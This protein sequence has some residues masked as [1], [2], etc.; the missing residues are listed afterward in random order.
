M[1]HHAWPGCVHTKGS[2]T[3]SVH[4]LFAKHYS[5]HSER[6][7]PKCV[8]SAHQAR[9]S[10]KIPSTK[11]QLSYCGNKAKW[12]EWGSTVL[13]HCQP[14]SLYCPSHTD[15]PGICTTGNSWMTIMRFSSLLKWG[16]LQWL[17]NDTTSLKQRGSSGRN[18]QDSTTT[19][20]FLFLERRR[21]A[22]PFSMDFTYTE[23]LQ[24]QSTQR[25]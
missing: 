1:Y 15:R 13:T 12:N 10:T 9:T 11:Q 24:W 19:L 23:S 7:I 25:E 18:T 4:G 6:D 14:L 3:D 16:C 21:Q 22:R 5:T 20:G 2:E 17:D 8:L